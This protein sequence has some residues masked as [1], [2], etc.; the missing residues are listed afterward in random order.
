LQ[1]VIYV[2]VVEFYFGT[3]A[4]GNSKPATAILFGGP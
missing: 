1:R 2:F 3:S 4:L